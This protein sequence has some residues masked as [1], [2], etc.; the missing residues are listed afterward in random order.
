MDFDTLWSSYENRKVKRR[1]QRNKSMAIICGVCIALSGLSVG[2]N[3]LFNQDKTDYAFVQDEALVGYWAVVDFVASPDAFD[4]EGR[5]LLASDYFE[6]FAF[7]GD[8]RVLIEDGGKLEPSH[9]RYSKGHVISTANGTD[10]LY[11]F[12][13]V[14]KETYLFLQ[15]KSGDY[16]EGQKVPKYY[17]L[18]QRDSLDR[19]LETEVSVRNDLIPTDFVSDDALIG[20]WQVV[21]FVA[22]KGSYDPSVNRSGRLPL[23]T[24][25]VYETGNMDFGFSNASESAAVDMAWT[26]GAVFAKVEKCLEPYVIETVGSDLILYLPWLSGDVIYRGQAPMYYVLKKQK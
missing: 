13:T 6:G 3:Q 1:S 16:T 18:K 26:K 5:E 9:L 23:K 2:A 14:G 15:W 12:K 4:G 21:D 19:E 7:A 10:G 25:T 22:E 17:V 8:G 24:V 11:Q 20:K